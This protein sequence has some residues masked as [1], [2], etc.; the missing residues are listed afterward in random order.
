MNWN[1]HFAKIPVL[2]TGLFLLLALVPKD[3]PKVWTSASQ[4]L[5]ELAQVRK[6]IKAPI[7]KNKD[8]PN[9]AA[10][11]LPV[12]GLAFVPNDAPPAS[13]RIQIP[14]CTICQSSFCSLCFNGK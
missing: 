5:Q 11:M 4:P 2:A 8:L 13:L 10:S 14:A 6:L 3:E 12:R 1:Y 7:F 9:K